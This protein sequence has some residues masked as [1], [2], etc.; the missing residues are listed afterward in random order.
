MLTEISIG[1]VLMSPL[2]PYLIVTIPLFWLTD[3]LLRRLGWY[4]FVWHADLVRVA[5]F[6]TMYS[7]LFCYG[8]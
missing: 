7:L 2:I 5:L 3:K 1:G 6:V 8:V 4:R